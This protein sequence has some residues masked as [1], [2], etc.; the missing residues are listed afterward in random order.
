DMPFEAADAAGEDVEK[1]LVVVP[2]LD[3]DEL[4]TPLERRLEPLAVTGDRQ[5]REVRREHDADDRLGAVG[6]GRLDR[7]GDPRLP[8]LHADEDRHSE[9]ALERGALALGDLVERR[10]PADPAVALLQL[11]DGVLGDR[12]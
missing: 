9:L 2:A 5:A 7:L 3:E 10:A 1:G 12:L 11:L 6:E 4:G 8:V